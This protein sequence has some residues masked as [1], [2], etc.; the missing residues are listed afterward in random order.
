V[1]WKSFDR[2]SVSILVPAMLVFVSGIIKYGERVWA[3]K[4]ASRKGLDKTSANPSSHEDTIDDVLTCTKESYALWTVLIARGFFVG[5]TMLLMGQGPAST[6]WFYLKT[7]YQGRE[8]KLKMVMM[9][10]ME[11]GMMFDLLYTKANVLQRRIGVLFRCAS[12]ALMVVALVLFMI[13]REEGAHNN[14]VNVAITYT[15]FSGAIFVETCCVAAAIAS[16]WTRAH[17]KESSCLHG[18]SD[19][20]FE[21]VHLCKSTA[22]NMAQFNLLDHCISVNSKPRVFSKAL[23]AIGLD[24]QW[25][26]HHMD[27]QCYWWI[28]NRVL[29]HLATL[30]DE[31]SGLATV[32]FTINAPTEHPVWF[33]QLSTSFEQVLYGL[34]LYTDLHLSRHFNNCSTGSVVQPPPPEIMRLKEECETLSNYM[35]YLMVVHP[36]MLPVNTV[37]AGDLVQ[38]LI[39]WVTNHP[40]HGATTT[41]LAILRGYSRTFYIL[42]ID[43]PGQHRSFYYL[44]HLLTQI[45]EMWVRLLMY[46]AGK[47]SGEVHARQLGEG[48]ELIT[49]VWLLMLHH[50]LGDMAAEFKLLRSNDPNVAERGAW[51]VSPPGNYQEPTCA[52]NHVTFVV[53]CKRNVSMLFTHTLQQFF[54]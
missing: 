4:S 51:I 15:L 12:Q 39:G 21:A 41:K 47:C 26:V 18:L 10:M 6:L 13:R 36:S 37:A 54:L 16:P 34:H 32:H 3:L 31:F 50:G 7:K 45:K 1:L 35:M 24:K 14:K 40:G 2:I 48:R 38:Q 33:N 25:Y 42:V 22:N 20:L 53:H 43:E 29:E 46:A 44:H 28:I 49:F 23:S 17:L 11:L 5:R 19:S 30:P 27:K 52:F 9:V 8:E